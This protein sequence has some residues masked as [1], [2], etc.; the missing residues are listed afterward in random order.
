MP[1]LVLGLVALAWIIARRLVRAGQR[2]GAVRPAAICGWAWR[3]PRPGS[4]SGACTPRTTGRMTRRGHV[5]G[6]RFYVPAIGAISLLG[7]W[8]ATR[9]PG[10]SWL[11]G[12]DR[13]P[14]SSRR[15]SAWARG[16]STPCTPPSVSRCT[17]SV[18]LEYSFGAPASDQSAL[19]RKGREH[20]HDHRR[21]DRRRASGKPRKGS[22]RQERQ[23][24]GEAYCKDLRS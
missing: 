1:M 12:A 10:R 17:G 22:S 19:C 23:T 13:R 4:R 16:P 11:A 20:H 18:A 6:V 15:C 21:Y 3:W 7:A 24:A 2:P 9:I 8:L 14:W 5:A